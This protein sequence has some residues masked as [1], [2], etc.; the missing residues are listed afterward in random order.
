[1]AVMLV[2]CCAV[3]G[4]V[5]KDIDLA[6]QDEVS[7][8]YIDKILETPRQQGDKVSNEEYQSYHKEVNENN[9]YLI[10]CITGNR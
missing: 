10:R 8:D 7:Q 9:G 3:L 1:M 4:L 6:N 2:L 5:A